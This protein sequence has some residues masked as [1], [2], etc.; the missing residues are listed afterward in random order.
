M[1]VEVGASYESAR[2]SSALKSYIRLQSVREKAKT[3]AFSVAPAAGH[4]T[5]EFAAGHQRTAGSRGACLSDRLVLRRDC[6]TRFV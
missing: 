4:S 2:A 6:P 3:G 5:G 1:G